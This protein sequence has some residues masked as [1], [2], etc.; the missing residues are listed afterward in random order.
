MVLTDL[1]EAKYSVTTALGAHAHL[2]RIK[3]K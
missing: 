3:K 1:A 2:G